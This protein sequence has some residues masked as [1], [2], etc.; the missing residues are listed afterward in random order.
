MPRAG[1]LARRGI[2]AVTL[3][4]IE[5]SCALELGA[6]KKT[7]DEPSRSAVRG[8]G[9]SNLRMRPAGGSVFN[10]APA[11]E[12]PARAAAAEPPAS[13]EWQAATPGIVDEMRAT[14]NKPAQAG[15]A[16]GLLGMLRRIASF[17]T[18]KYFRNV[19]QSAG[20]FLGAWLWY[21]LNSKTYIRPEYDE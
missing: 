16:I 20:V 3:L 19:R 17:F 4:L 8:D 15:A 11:P 14:I 1:A 10:D 18:S 6:S 12:E 21:V 13:A 2:L 9:S 5:C 7:A